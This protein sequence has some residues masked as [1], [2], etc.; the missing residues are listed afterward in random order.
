MRSGNLKPG[1]LKPGNLQPG[2]LQPGNLQ[3][4][5]LQP[6]NLQRWIQIQGICPVCRCRRSIIVDK[7]D[8]R[9]APG[10][11]GGEEVQRLIAHSRPG[12][13][14]SLVAR[15]SDQLYQS[16][17]D[18][19]ADPLIVVDRDQRIVLF[20]RAAE[21]VFGYG[22][23]EVLGNDLNLLIPD[24]YHATHPHQVST[25]VARGNGHDTPAW[26]RAPVKARRSDGSVFPAEVSLSALEVDGEPLFA[27]ALRDVSARV[28]TERALAV[29]E[30]RFRA[31]FEKSPVAMVLIRFDGEFA[32]G[33]KAFFEQTGYTHDDLEGKWL[34][35]IVCEEDRPVLMSELAPLVAGTEDTAQV[36]LRYVRSNGEVRV[37]DLFM[38]T[39]GDPGSG[40]HYMIGQ[41]I[42]VTD[43]IETRARLEEL[44][45]SKDQLI[46]SISHE[47]R[48][49]L[50]SLVGFSQLL[51]EG[52]SGFTAGERAEM[53]E[54]IVTE[55][56]DL[57]NIVEDL[58]VAAKAESGALSV[59]HVAVDLRAQAAQ[60]LEMWNR[61]D[62][63]GMELEGDSPKAWGDPA[64]V[65]Q[66]LRNLISNA[67]RYGVEP[68]T[69]EVRAG[70]TMA[71]VAVKDRGA[72]IDLEDRDRIFEPYQR[73]HSV[74]G[75]TA[76]MG[77]GLSISRQL[78]RLMDGELSYRR[79][80]DGNVF[81]LTLRLVG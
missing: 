79:A 30:L 31:T 17:T 27:A 10:Q 46:T 68:I 74:E 9:G 78:A 66:I 76:S 56:V 48:T 71:V 75:V 58:L 61:G 47:L 57:T 53:I 77:L 35:S 25:F 40:P 43:R 28:D 22:V 50:T 33:N 64:R 55:S 18:A 39:T 7:V 59:A 70:E 42:D 3:P 24:E 69:V 29:S 81:E 45:R 73:A 15:V 16:L 12:E 51:H 41:A 62:T 38:A 23:N 11:D 60:I 32:T 5:N 63:V 72:P 54:S 37:V 6:D 4:D 21:R 44:I 80:P 36:E 26:E 1:N 14:G 49:P 34:G 13:G 19:V 20:N 2:N 67:V 8:D 65:R 52:Q